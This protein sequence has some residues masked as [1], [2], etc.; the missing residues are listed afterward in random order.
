MYRSPQHTLQ[1]VL[2]RIWNTFV[3]TAVSWAH[4]EKKTLVLIFCFYFSV[5]VIWHQC[6]CSY[7]SWCLRYFRVSIF[8]YFTNRPGNDKQRPPVFN[9]NKDTHYWCAAVHRRPPH[10]PMNL[11]KFYTSKYAY[12]YVNNEATF[13][14]LFSS[15][16]NNCQSTLVFILSVRILK[17]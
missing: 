12:A 9:N 13:V 1:L 11:I 17:V 3:L 10:T 7:N 2:F 5:F 16:Y 15:F 6:F 14:Y 8:I 4:K